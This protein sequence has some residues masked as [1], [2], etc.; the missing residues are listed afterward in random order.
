MPEEVG[1]ATPRE[2][3]PLFETAAPVR[4]R[5][6]GHGHD[7]SHKPA[8]PNSGNNTQPL[9]TR[10]H[11]GGATPPPRLAILRAHWGRLA[12]PAATLGRMARRPEEI[13]KD[14]AIVILEE[15]DAGLSWDEWVVA[16]EEDEPI[17]LSVPA[18]ETLREVRAAD[19]V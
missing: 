18:A 9:E 1:D 8:P 10:V 2:E 3:G 13:H 4:P 14:P 5:F 12:R 7:E 16:L 15:D 11:Q 17:E 19:E 6:K